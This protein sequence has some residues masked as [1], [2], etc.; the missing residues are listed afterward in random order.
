MSKI[1]IIN[2]T[3]GITM[4][5]KICSYIG[6]KNTKGF[7]EIDF[8]DFIDMVDSGLSNE[9][10]A[11]ELGVNRLQVDKLKNQLHRDY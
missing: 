2:S 1:E 4:N 3:G 6:E 7:S 11:V 9:E 5:K 8:H 10:I